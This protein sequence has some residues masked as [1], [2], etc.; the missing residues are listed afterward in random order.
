[1]VALHYLKY[2]H[3]L[4]DEAVVTRWTENPHWQ[5]FSGRQFFEHEMPIDPS[6]MTRWRKPLG[7]AGAE[8]TLKSTNEAG[9]A[10]KAITSAQSHHVNVDTTLQIKELRHPTDA[11]LYARAR[12]RLVKA[13]RKLGIKIKQS[14]TSASRR[15]VMQASRYAH[16]LQMNRAKACVCKPRNHLGRVLRQIE[17]QKDKLS[18]T[19]SHLLQTCT[20][21]YEAYGHR[22]TRGE[23]LGVVGHLRARERI[24]PP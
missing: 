1:M 16:A 15:L 7:S 18:A 12:E 19:A 5:H 6:S 8:T 23:F 22:R 9:I 14:C 4:S 13:A 21:I 20:R 24:A 3:N 17:T 2:Q 11:R 10:I